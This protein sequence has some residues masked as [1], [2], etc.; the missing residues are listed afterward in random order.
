[1]IA[2][3]QTTDLAETP[4]QG[5]DAALDGVRSDHRK[6]LVL[7]LLF[8]TI[9]VVVM[10]HSYRESKS[11]IQHTSVEN[12]KIYA[13]AIEAF[14]TLYTS[15][16]VAR[17]K[18]AG[19]LITHD[20]ENHANA[21]PL[22]ATLSMQ[23][24]KMIGGM[25]GGADVRLY[26]DHPFPWRNDGGPQDSFEV[27][28]LTALRSKPTEPYYAFENVDGR[29]T[30]RFAT[31]DL[32]RQ[33]CIN[34]HND[35]PDT[36]RGNWKVG[37]VRGVLAVRLP[38]DSAAAHSSES[39]EKTFYLLSLLSVV[40][41][42]GL[43]LAS[44][45]Q[46][47][48]AAIL[49]EN[50]RRLEQANRK[51]D[52]KQKLLTESLKKQDAQYQEL[53]AVK[54][55][56][57]QRA[58]ELDNS[59]RAAVNMMCDANVAREKA[60]SAEQKERAQA[61]KLQESTIALVESQKKLAATSRQAGMA[62]VATGVLHNVGNVL[63]SVNVSANLIAENVSEGRVEMLEKAIE[64]MRQNQGDLGAYVTTDPKGKQLP[65]LL[66]ELSSTLVRERDSTIGELQALVRNV[67]H[68]KDIVTRQQS[69][70]RVSGIVEQSE[71]AELVDDAIAVFDSSFMRQDVEMERDYQAV[72]AIATERSKVVQILVNL[73]GN[74]QR[75]L[76]DAE[77]SE[78]RLVISIAEVSREQVSVRVKDNGRGH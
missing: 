44:K 12:A 53:I 33:S 65:R 62:E 23:L 16:V 70:A 34:C 9:I 52:D 1:M 42:W 77:N 13:N 22:P 2:T 39:L 31:A 45:R 50:N 26:S 68:I 17:A 73:V 57:D 30:L 66:T 74:A 6:L 15:E 19:M 71:V 47:R 24:G 41:V 8:C 4:N 72:P 46:R 32:M 18:N 58:V 14:R 43:S 64:L 7:A 37:D 78:K 28:A 75:A 51:L 40:A 10:W 49:F 76:S 55:K 36:P 29:Q 60:E 59:R 54:R 69:Y 35:H 27:D 63:N 25:Y 21:M 61:V 38:L 11:L 56:D 3:H 48:N 67:D 5:S 20:Y